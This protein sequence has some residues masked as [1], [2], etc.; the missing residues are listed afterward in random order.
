MPRYFW[1]TAEILLR[2]C[3]VKWRTGLHYFNLKT[4]VCGLD[5]WTRSGL[6]IMPL[7]LIEPIFNNFLEN[8]LS[9][10]SLKFWRDFYVVHQIYEKCTRHIKSRRIFYNNFVWCLQCRWNETTSIKLLLSGLDQ[11]L[12]TMGCPKH[13]TKQKKLPHQHRVKILKS[14]W[15]QLSL[16]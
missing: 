8:G 11:L 14:I 13:K 12:V 7:I 2:Y 16:K 10:K 9:R 15:R 4:L 3:W 5:G 6:F 1:D